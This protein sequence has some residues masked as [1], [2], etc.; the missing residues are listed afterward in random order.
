MI[1]VG[2][3][4]ANGLIALR[5][6]EKRPDIRLLVIESGPH[7]GGNHTWSFHQHDLTPAQHV[8][9]APLI[10][11]R[12]PGYDVRFPRHARTLQQGYYSITS[13]HFA[14]HLQAQ[15]GDRLRL[16]TEVITVAPQQV[17]LRD[18]TTLT[19]A[20]VIDGRGNLSNPHLTLGVQAFLG[21]EWTLAAPHGLQHPI[22]MDA[23]VAQQ[24]GYRFVYTLPLSPTRLL[25]EDT[26]Y[27]DAAP[28]DVTALRPA[29][30][31]YAQQQGWLLQQL[32]REEQ[33]ALP[34]TLAGDVAAFWH[35]H[36]GQPVSGLRAGLFHPVTGYSLPDAVR[37]AERIAAHPSLTA[38]ALFSVLQHHATQQWQQ[39]RFLRMLNRM[40][41]WAAEPEQRWRV[42]QRFYQLPAALIA[43]FYAGQ[44]TAA[45]K[46][47]LLIGKPPV[48]LLAALR[49]ITQRQ[50]SQRETCHE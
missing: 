46:A 5:L 45:D 37:L 35:H 8:W 27:R 20:A 44:L 41:F 25:I 16:A 50:A 29:I 7:A 9:M 31:A 4:L 48:P 49:A 15:L 18:G 39:Q 26:H 40:L 10:S 32:I 33:G 19:A 11:H 6:L 23:T 34:L 1:L 42:M 21:Q 38:D 17:T 36:A 14:A 12:W 43:R 24:G 30:A 2:A 22:L 13:T 47:R 28:A 3:G